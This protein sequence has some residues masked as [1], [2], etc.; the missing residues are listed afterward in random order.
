MALKKTLFPLLFVGLLTTLWLAAARATGE[1]K[2]AARDDRARDREAIRAH[3]DK[4]FRAYVDGD[5]ATIR[6]THAPD[7]IGFTGRARSIVRGLDQYMKSSAGFCGEGGARRGPEA[8]AQASLVDYKLTEI[9]FKF[10]GDVALVPYVAET[11][12]G[13]DARTP[14]KLRSLDVY[15]KLNGEWI[16]VGS[17]IFPH[18][19]MI[20]ALRRQAATS[21]PSAAAFGQEVSDT[22]YMTSTGE[23]VLRLEVVLPVGKAEA[24]KLF[25]TEEGWKRW[26]APVVSMDF[27]VGGQV[28]TN[29]DKSKRAGDL[30][31][32]RLPIINYLEGEMITL[33][34][35]LNESF[36]DRAR[37]EDKNL[38]EVIQLFDAGQGRTRVVSSMVGWGTGPD[39][40][41]TYEFFRKGNRWTYQQLLKLFPSS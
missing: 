40:D 16:Q 1:G 14:G 33:K 32:I 24:W 20:E 26:A 11:W 36:A 13:R 3:I 17:N 8:L 41:K 37:Q 27:K 34:V 12:Y 23:K 10:Y 9:D 5:C 30:G 38:Q 6:A 31:T 25:S 19:D 7:W 39:W 2:I 4:I 35:I 22:S 18:P 28:L 29:Y 15:A 21:Q